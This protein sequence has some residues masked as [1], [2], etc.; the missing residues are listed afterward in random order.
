MNGYATTLTNVLS[1]ALGFTKYNVDFPGS[2]QFDAL[3]RVE[4]KMTSLFTDTKVHVFVY[5]SKFINAF[6]IPGVNKAASPFFIFMRQFE[7]IFPPLR[8]LNVFGYAE[9]WGSAISLG[10][11]RNDI[12]IWNPETKKITMSL[13]EVTVYASSSLIAMCT[14]DEVTAVL[15]H[16]VGHNTMIMQAILK[17]IIAGSGAVSV[18]YYFIIKL[19]ESIKK[20]EY[21]DFLSELAKVG[22]FNGVLI[23][24]F[25]VLYYY[26]ARRHE[27]KADEF[28][29]KCGYG[30]HLLSFEKKVNQ[31]DLYDNPFTSKRFPGFNV[32]DRILNAILR[33]YNWIGNLMAA[34]GLEA[35]PAVW[36]RVRQIE[37]KTKMYDISD[38]NIDRSDS[39]GGNN[40]YDKFFIYKAK[41][42]KKSNR[43]KN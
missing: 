39:I 26:M 42:Y 29:I 2:V 25:F 21:N 23:L 33:L 43:K 7:K 41:G 27:V 4:K 32:V 38:K 18:V 3:P 5:A 8:F 11:K 22:I 1:T 35:H 14:D 40:L 30:E 34:V 37:E 10:N 28:A 36:T 24:A 6:T 16:E 31:M 13:K 20:G 9:M 17:D 15:L 19:W 12:C